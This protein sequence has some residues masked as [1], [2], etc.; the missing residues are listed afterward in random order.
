MLT[1]KRELG[2][3]NEQTTT[4]TQSLSLI[5]EGNQ[6]TNPDSPSDIICDFN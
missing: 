5:S 2:V 1:I 3:Q 6:T 4:V